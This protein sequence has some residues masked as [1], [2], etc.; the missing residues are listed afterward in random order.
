[1]FR[2]LIFW[3]GITVIVFF[4][5]AWWDSSQR[6]T[7]QSG[8]NILLANR[9]SGVS[10]CYRSDP[11][12]GWKIQPSSI[13]ATDFGEES[14]YPRL[15]RPGL[16]VWRDL[17]NKEKIELWTTGKLEGHSLDRVLLDFYLDPHLVPGT[18]LIYIPYWLILLVFV[19]LWLGFLWWRTRR[20]KGLK[21]V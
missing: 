11:P 15:G 8:G 3:F 10:L 21:R 7:F 2:S 13:P 19:A 18:R 20:E 16:T 1:M 6:W 9:D 5:W 12:F 4:C 14:G 17:N